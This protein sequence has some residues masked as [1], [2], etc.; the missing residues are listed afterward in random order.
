MGKCLS[1]VQLQQYAQD[2]YARPIPV[3]P[4]DEVSADRADIEAFEV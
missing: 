1:D 2:G 4:N 3:L